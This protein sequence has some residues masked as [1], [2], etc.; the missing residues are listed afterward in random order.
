MW[1]L[2]LWQKCRLVCTG[3]YG[4][5]AGFLVYAQ[6]PEAQPSSN[7]NN[8][9]NE[10]PAYYWRG[11]YIHMRPVFVGE[12]CTPELLEQYQIASDG[13]P[14]MLLVMRSFIM[15]CPVYGGGAQADIASELHARLTQKDSLFIYWWESESAPDIQTL[16]AK[17][18]ELFVF[19]DF[20]P[21]GVYGWCIIEGK[22]EE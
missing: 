21:E 20:P 16:R 14:G 22:G 19:M 15:S 10:K 6:S 5:I 13:K 4:V 11:D 12:I 2:A 7:H 9:T 8:T 17:V 18:N 1:G 3:F